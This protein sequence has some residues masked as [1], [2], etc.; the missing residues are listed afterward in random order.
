MPDADEY[1][2]ICIVQCIVKEATVILTMLWN[3]HRVHADYIDDQ[4][5]P[6]PIR[7]VLE[8]LKT[9]RDH[10]PDED[11]EH[12]IKLEALAKRVVFLN[13]RTKRAIKLYEDFDQKYGIGQDNVLQGMRKVLGIHTMRSSVCHWLLQHSVEFDAL[14]EDAVWWINKVDILRDYVRRDTERFKWFALL[15]PQALHRDN[16]LVLL[17]SAGGLLCNTEH[18]LRMLKEAICEDDS[19]PFVD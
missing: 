15:E 10:G 19:M 7:D 11:D 12:E 8:E 14:M 2:R 17:T 1:L 3:D 16:H 13:K 18:E 4:G 5:M 9:G 6:V